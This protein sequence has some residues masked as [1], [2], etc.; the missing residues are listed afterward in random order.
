[1]ELVSQLSPGARARIRALSGARPAR[2][3]QTLVTTWLVIALAI[4]AALTF[5]NV[6]VS[7]IAIYF[8]ATRQQL[9]ALLVHEQTHS[10]GLKGRYGDMIGNLFTAYP[11]IAVTIE[12]YAKIHLRHHR[13]Y[14]TE[15]DPDFLRKQGPDWTFP[16]PLARLL[17]LFLLDISGVSFVR[18]MLDRKK[19]AY[20]GNGFKRKHPVPSWLKPA[21]LITV[22]VVLTL[23]HGWT[24]FLLYWAL[25]LVT[26]FPAIVRW[27][28]ICEHSYGQE[29]ATVEE[30]SP[31]IL[32]NWVSRIFYPNMNF[33]MHVYHHHFPTVSFSNLPAVHQ[34]FVEEDLVRKDQLFNGHLDYLRYILKGPR[35]GRVAPALAA[36]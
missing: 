18:Y 17:G 29:G 10:L 31:V 20:T 11:L 26:I 3:V 36:N 32:P 14:F 34:I 19:R 8:V 9:L 5:Q 21:F 1:M 6:F 16:M 35:E 2:Y 27:G 4:T 24:A 28:A 23:V 13:H 12:D 25:P 30:T 22:A 15:A 7:I 33:S